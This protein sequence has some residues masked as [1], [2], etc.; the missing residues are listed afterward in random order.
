[1]ENDPMPSDTADPITVL[2]VHLAGQPPGQESFFMCRRSLATRL[3]ADA[4][5]LSAD[6]VDDL[7]PGALLLAQAAN[8]GEWARGELVLIGVA[9]GS[10]WLRWLP[11]SPREPVPGSPGAAAQRN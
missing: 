7:G 1:M 9:E 2:R 5:G 8:R 6:Q 3:G 10:R 11:P 4:A